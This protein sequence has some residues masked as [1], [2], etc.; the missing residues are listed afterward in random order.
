MIP[1]DEELNFAI[2]QEPEFRVVRQR[3][4]VPPVQHGDDAGIL[5]FLLTAA[6]VVFGFMIRSAMIRSAFDPATTRINNGS[7]SPSQNVKA[8]QTENQASLPEYFPAQHDPSQLGPR[9][10]SR[11]LRPLE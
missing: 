1:E 8:S 7:S 5:V 6:I 9:C 10:R 4:R 11:L 3:R 2:P